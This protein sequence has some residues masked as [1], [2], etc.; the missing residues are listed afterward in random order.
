M[1]ATEFIQK[2]E[3][4]LKVTLADELIAFVDAK[5]EAEE[6]VDQ[7]IDTSYVSIDQDEFRKQVLEKCSKIGLGIDRCNNILI[8]INI[9]LEDHLKKQG[10]YVQET[11]IHNEPVEI[12]PRQFAIDEE[13]K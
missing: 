13:R 7:F 5:I 2:V 3:E 11:G 10:W 6:A 1:N 8:T 4:S 9:K 12:I